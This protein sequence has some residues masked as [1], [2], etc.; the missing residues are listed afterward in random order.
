M[1]TTKATTS[2]NSSTEILLLPDGQMLVHN[3][4]SAVAA[5]LA[6]LNPHD[7]LMA[8]RACAANAPCAKLQTTDHE[9]LTKS[10]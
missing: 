5:V 3:L 2:A 8:A 6:E 7:E 4:T 10:Q 9:P 1:R